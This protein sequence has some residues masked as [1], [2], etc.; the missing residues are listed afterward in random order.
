LRDYLYI[1]LGGNRHGTWKTYR[2]LAL[3]MLLG[4]LWHGASWT[5]VVWGAF[6]G[7]LLIGHRLATPL[8]S[9]I[10]G[11][12][13][14]AGRRLARAVRIV[15]FFH[16]TCLG[17]LIFRAESLGQLWTMLGR[18]ALDLSWAPLLARPEL[19]ASFV[20]CVSILWVVQARQYLRD[21]LMVIYR[22]NPALRTGFYFLCLLLAVLF[23]VYRSEEFIYFQF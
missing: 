21:D 9:R 4:G 20:F 3:T 19:V 13:S 6:H 8:I 23:G 7:L 15:C 11:P 22:M 10:P 2:N 5:F 16:L 17:W 14:V 18:L 1:P 12:S